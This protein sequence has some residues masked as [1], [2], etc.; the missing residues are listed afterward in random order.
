MSLI[1]SGSITKD[2]MSK[3]NVNPCGVSSLRVKATSV[4]CMHCD[5][6]IHGRYAGV[7]MVAPMF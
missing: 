7:K 6:W 5:K 4:L 2:G 3:S 1:F